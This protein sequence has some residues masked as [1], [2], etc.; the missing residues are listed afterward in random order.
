[1]VRRVFL[2]CSQP[3]AK[4]KMS[5]WFPMQRCT[6]FL[7]RSRLLLAT[8]NLWLILSLTSVAYF[9][10]FGLPHSS[11]SLM[12]IE[13]LLLSFWRLRKCRL[14]RFYGRQ[15]CYTVNWILGET[16]QR[17][18][19]CN[20]K[21][22]GWV[23]PEHRQ[24]CDVSLKMRKK[25]CRN[26]CQRILVGCCP[27]AEFKA[28]TVIENTTFEPLLSNR[29]HTSTHAPRLSINIIW[30]RRKKLESKTRRKGKEKRLKKCWQQ[31]RAT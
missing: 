17:R 19:I 30:R 24:L 6:R 20:F 1:M 13:W 22:I 18:I 7:V 29:T 21:L 10:R 9:R 28:K 8:K 14:L 3:S 16:A 27:E 23:E 12:P 2:S 26:V 5:S 4:H 15:F 25:L 31:Q 11:K